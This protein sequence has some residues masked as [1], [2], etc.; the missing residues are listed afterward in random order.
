MPTTLT[1]PIPMNEDE[2]LS[3]L[4]RYDILDSEKEQ[5]FDDL[6]RLA[7]DITGTPVSLITLVDKDR[8]WIKSNVGFDAPE[9][10]REGAFCAHTIMTEDGMVV[11][12]VSLDARFQNGVVDAEKSVRF[13][14][15][16]PLKTRDGYNLGT[17]CVVD[18]KPR[19][20]SEDA[21][22][23][24][25]MLARQAM[26]Q[27]EL[28]HN[29]GALAKTTRKAI[30]L[31]NLMK[32]YTSRSVWERADLTVE[33]GRLDIH[34]EEVFAT[35]LF[36][37]VVGFTRFSEELGSSATVELLNAYFRPIVDVVFANGG[38]IDK[39]VGDQL[40]C[41]FQDGAQAVATALKIRAML[42]ELN[43]ER[44]VRGD[45]TLNVTMGLHSG[46]AIRANVGGDDR[47][48]NTLIGNAVN[49]AA[50]LQKACR[51]GGI[52]ISQTLFESVQPHAKSEQ[53][54]RLRLKNLTETVLAHYIDA[55]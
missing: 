38:D 45:V 8:V 44:A 40:F 29:L 36:L 46:Q 7:A 1:T 17:L 25:K 54:V 49:I 22:A 33:N 14:A 11:S 51:P 4:R 53:Q 41:L 30:S 28:R 19:E 43:Q 10:P 34:D 24:L 48:D 39:F 26:A 27:I 12:D 6:T 13:Y 37:D 23:R 47:R 52:L 18:T 55:P 32:R 31:E 15:G 21:L 2:R 35:Y 50:R 9:T 20:I 5:L 3:A 42:E 16:T